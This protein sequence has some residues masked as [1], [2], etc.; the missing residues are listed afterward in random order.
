MFCPPR[1][2]FEIENQIE[3]LCLEN[4]CINVYL[5]GKY[6]N[7]PF[8]T[9]AEFTQG[10]DQQLPH[11]LFGRQIGKLRK[12]EDLEAIELFRV[13]FRDK[14]SDQ[15]PHFGVFVGEKL[16]GR[17]HGLTDGVANMKVKILSDLKVEKIC[18]IILGWY[19][20]TSLRS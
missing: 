6:S 1:D 16:E 12:R 2:A 15:Q 7:L 8:G 17:V 19:S 5:K 11:S 3:L 14:L 9:F 18:N 13:K 10:K 20:Q 4:I